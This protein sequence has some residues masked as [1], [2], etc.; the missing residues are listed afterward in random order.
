MSRRHAQRLRRRWI[1]WLRRASG[2][3][4]ATKKSSFFFLLRILELEQISDE[5]VFLGLEISVSSRLNSPP[6]HSE[7]RELTFRYRRGVKPRQFLRY[8]SAIEAW[9]V[10]TKTSRLFDG[11]VLFVC[12]VN[13]FLRKFADHVVVGCL[14]SFMLRSWSRP[15]MLLR[16]RF[17]CLFAVYLSVLKC[18]R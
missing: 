17:P 5:T 3:S 12:L 15:V 2:M 18:D 13:H 11:I 10:L 4:L 1:A 9:V 16:S 14:P 6:F 8:I 7:F